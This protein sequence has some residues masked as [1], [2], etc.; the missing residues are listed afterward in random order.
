[1]PYS[2]FEDTSLFKI[3]YHESQQEDDDIDLPEF[4]CN[5]L[6]VIG[7][8][9]EE[10]EAPVNHPNRHKEEIPLQV[11]TVQSGSLFCNKAIVVEDGNK[12]QPVKPTCHFRDNKFS[13]DFIAFIFHPPASIA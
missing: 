1:M 4:I 7:E 10:E 13:T 2:N 12:K 11:Q 6:L 8:L 5:K 9:F 3:L